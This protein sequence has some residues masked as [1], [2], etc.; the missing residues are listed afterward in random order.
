LLERTCVDTFPLV[1]GLRLSS[2]APTSYAKYF[3]W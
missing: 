1:F 3:L 2:F